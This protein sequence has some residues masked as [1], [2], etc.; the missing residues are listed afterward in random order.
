[1][2]GHTTNTLYCYQ[3]QEIFLILHLTHIM[4]SQ[5]TTWKK[6]TNKKVFSGKSVS[7]AWKVTRSNPMV[8]KLVWNLYTFLQSL[9][10]NNK[11]AFYIKSVCD[12]PPSKIL[13]F[14][15]FVLKA[16]LPRIQYKLNSSQIACFCSWALGTNLHKNI[17]KHTEVKCAG[18]ELSNFSIHWLQKFLRDCPFQNNR[19]DS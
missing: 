17:Y 1:M 16:E 12:K 18:H 10:T 11:A 13:H 6:L 2:Y 19:Y 9:Q 15:S 7:H 14:N 8:G 3:E 5:Q 4:T